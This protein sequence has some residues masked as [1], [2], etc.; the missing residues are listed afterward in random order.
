MINRCTNGGEGKEPRVSGPQTFWSMDHFMV[1][2]KEIGLLR[3]CR[4]NCTAFDET[5]MSE[6]ISK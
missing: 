3:I 4:D 6:R 1:V 5:P 2:L